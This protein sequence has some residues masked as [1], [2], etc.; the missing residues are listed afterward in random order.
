MSKTEMGRPFEPCWRDRAFQ[1]FAAWYPTERISDSKVLRS[2]WRGAFYAFRPQVP[3]RMR[4]KHYEV[5]VKPG[6]RHLTRKL[7]RRGNWEAFETEVMLDILRPG[8]TFVDGGANFGHYSLT[9]ARRVGSSGIVH[10]FEPH[11]ELFADL[12]ANIALNSLTSV[13]AVNGALG[14][15]P[16]TL[17]LY[18]DD[19]NA[20]GHSL[21]GSAVRIPGRH[22]QTQ[23]HRLDD[24]LADRSAPVDL[25]KLDTQGAEGFI[26]QG[27]QRIL[28]EDRPSLLVEYWPEMLVKTG[29]DPAGFLRQF[30]ELGYRIDALIDGQRR[31]I[32]PED[33]LRLA[34]ER[35]TYLDL[36]VAPGTP[37]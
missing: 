23:V 5:L 9:A 6:Q 14:A 3:F 19:G 28:A 30:V 27:A 16:G 33:A 26:L 7:I 32:S 21:I 35:Q 25:M 31:Q 15:A 13:K 8:M 4:T 11:P 20:G 10:A 36:L 2:I 12:Q 1:D 22:V 18:L 24:L 34:G 29:F 17:D 37:A